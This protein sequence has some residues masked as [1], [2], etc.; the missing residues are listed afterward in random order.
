MIRFPTLLLCLFFSTHLFAA[1]SNSFNDALCTLIYGNTG[2]CS[3]T[4]KKAQEIPENIYDL[5]FKE[6]K[7][8]NKVFPTPATAQLG[9]HLNLIPLNSSEQSIHNIWLNQPQ[10]GESEKNRKSIATQLVHDLTI[11]LYIHPFN[12]N[13]S[14]SSRL[15]NQP[16][17]VADA[18]T[19][20]ERIREHC[21]QK[22]NYAACTMS[23][24]LNN[25]NGAGRALKNLITINQQL[26]IIKNITQSCLKAGMI[27]DTLRPFPTKKDNQAKNKEAIDNANNIG[28]ETAF[29]FLFSIDEKYK[30]KCYTNSPYNVSIVQLKKSM[31]ILKKAMLELSKMKMTNDQLFHSTKQKTEFETIAQIDDPNKRSSVWKISMLQKTNST[32]SK[33]DATELIK[34]IDLYTNQLQP[35]IM[36]LTLHL[37]SKTLPDAPTLSTGQSVF[38]KSSFHPAVDQTKLD[39]CSSLQPS[40]FTLEKSPRLTPEIAEMKNYFNMIIDSDHNPDFFNA[41]DAILPSTSA[42]DLPVLAGGQLLLFDSNNDKPNADLNGQD[43]QAKNNKITFDAI[44]DYRRNEIKKI[45]ENINAYNLNLDLF[46]TKKSTNA[47]ILESLFTNRTLQYK[48]KSCGIKLTPIEII[49]H[50]ATYRLTQPEW[51]ER[52]QSEQSVKTLTKE[53]LMIMAEY[54]AMEDQ[55]RRQREVMMILMN[56]NLTALQ[57]NSYTLAMHQ[58]SAYNQTLENYINGKDQRQAKQMNLAME[59]NTEEKKNIGKD[60]KAQKPVKP[61]KV[62]SNKSIKDTQTKNKEAKNTKA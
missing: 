31:S 10:E 29:P 44:M 43:L 15:L 8:L 50:N 23:N 18:N 62:N 13:T 46:L 58:K 24:S 54:R 39:K 57:K 7:P 53:M 17:K 3:T 6:K 42:S 61:K 35:W 56:N 9:A 51:K 40:D 5:L 45:Q 20:S 19:A 48:S 4:Q 49:K 36:P 32:M 38:G 27:D 2:K 26:M 59:K 55:I 60:T 37:L 25:Q 12:S 34:K 11:P 21:R 41:T 14:R 33:K 22:N 28:N 16:Y 1:E 30:T 47:S 52:I